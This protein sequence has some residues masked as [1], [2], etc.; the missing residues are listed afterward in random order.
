M[1][2][3]TKRNSH[4]WTRLIFL[5]FILYFVMLLAFFNNLPN[6][7]RGGHQYVSTFVKERDVRRRPVLHFVTL[8]KTPNFFIVPYQKIITFFTTTNR[9][10]PFYLFFFILVTACDSR[11]QQDALNLVEIMLSR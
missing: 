6:G 5:K 9:V 2:N 8:H 1:L 3:S 11:L 10:I 7:V 4:R